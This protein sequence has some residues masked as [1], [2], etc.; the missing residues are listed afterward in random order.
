MTKIYNKTALKERRRDLRKV[1][2][3]AEDLLWKLLRNRN[4]KGY[5]FK[6]Q[7]S[8][9]GYILDFYCP[10][11][12]LAIELDGA[13]HLDSERTKYDAQRTKIINE[14]DLTVVRFSNEEVSN[15]I[16]Y[17]LNEIE[18]SIAVASLPLSL[19]RRGERGVR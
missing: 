6:R 16:D 11:I 14:C 15:N 4:I 12:K 3:K 10:E 7:Y 8:V 13:Y 2:T 17:V 9:G 18:K 5:K 1:S 19:P